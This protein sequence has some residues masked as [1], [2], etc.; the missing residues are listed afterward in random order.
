M[1]FSEMGISKQFASTGS[2]SLTGAQLS[3]PVKIKL[4][5]VNKY[6]LCPKSFVNMLNQI[7][8]IHKY[9]S[10]ELLIFLAIHAS[11]SHYYIKDFCF[12]HNYENQMCRQRLVITSMENE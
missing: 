5:L 4:Y 2:S 3:N 6:S 7:L 1:V 8:I 11:N 9:L 12:S 10:S